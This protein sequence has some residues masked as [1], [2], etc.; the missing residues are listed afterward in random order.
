MSSCYLW[1]PYLHTSKDYVL[2]CISIEKMHNM[3]L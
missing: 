3:K 1:S 2:G